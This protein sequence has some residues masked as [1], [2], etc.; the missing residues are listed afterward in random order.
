METKYRESSKA[1]IFNPE[2]KKYLVFEEL[3]NPYVNF[4]YSAIGGGIDEG[5]S[6]DQALIREFEEETGISRERITKKVYLGK[7]IYGWVFKP[8]NYNLK[9]TSY[10][11]YMEIDSDF[12]AFEA[13]SCIARWLDYKELPQNFLFSNF[14][15]LLDGEYQ[16]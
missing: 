3:H 7:S 16:S 8:D 6:P 11:Y 4:K 15:S 10:N 2:T 12:A 1:I 5:E 13:D 14:Q 9:Q